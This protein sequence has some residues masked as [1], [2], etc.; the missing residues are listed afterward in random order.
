MNTSTHPIAEDVMALIDQELPPTEAQRIAAHL[1][2]CQSC[3]DVA[4]TTRRTSQTL[5]TWTVPPLPP[6]IDRRMLQQ[7]RNAQGKKPRGGMSSGFPRTRWNGRLWAAGAACVAVFLLLISRHPIRY[8]NTPPRALP[9]AETMAKSES[10]VPPINQ[11]LEQARENYERALEIKKREAMSSSLAVAPAPPLNGRNADQMVSLTSPGAATD[12]NG[13]FHGLGDRAATAFS[14]DGEAQGTDAPMIARVVSV[15]VVVKDYI[16]SRMTLEAILRRHHGYAADLTAN[17]AEGSQRSLEASLRV[18]A[19]EL[20]AT[21]ADLKA[22]GRVERET[23]NGEEVSQQH[24]DL[25]ARLKNSRE[26]EKRLQAILTERTGKISD[27]LEV[28][29]EIARVRGEIEEMEAAQ[30]SLE[31]RVDFATVNMSL[32]EE[33]KA[34]LMLPGLSAGTRLHNALIEGFHNAGETLLGIMLFFAQFGLTLLIWG[35]ILLV[36]AFFLWCRFRRALATV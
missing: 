12:S 2:E 27:V 14:V 9:V 23:Q 19:N 13:F 18:P 15:S 1:K 10:S 28:E 25:V 32:S 35:L 6:D 31:R 7:A 11:G 34:G 22:L 5:A 20:D 24:A 29:Q 30:K 33:Y 16:A 21:I 36:P 3:A 4:E 8:A 17:T 26:T